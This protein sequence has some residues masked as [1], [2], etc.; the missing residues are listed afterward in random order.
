MN[1]F[2]TIDSA[3]TFITQIVRK[4]WKIWPSPLNHANHEIYLY[5][6]KVGG[7]FGLSKITTPRD[8]KLQGW[9]LAWT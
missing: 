9:H 8:L 7:I 5:I 3:M 4:I 6:Y 2:L 1:S